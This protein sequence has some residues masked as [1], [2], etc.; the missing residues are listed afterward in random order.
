MKKNDPNK[1]R[2]EAVDKEGRS[3]S[4]DDI[5]WELVKDEVN[6][7]QLD[8]K[9]QVISLPRNMKYIQGKT[10]SATLGSNKVEIESRYI[11]VVHKN[12]KFLIRVDEKTNDI[13]IE[14]SELPKNP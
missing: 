12:T 7:L 2:W 13:S 3:I 8:N 9:G 14:V 5:N 6:Y 1:R 4:E 11:G 10:A